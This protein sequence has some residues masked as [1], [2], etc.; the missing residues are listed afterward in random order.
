MPVT[1]EDMRTVERVA[2]RFVRFVQSSER[3]E[4]VSDGMLALA[5]AVTDWE[6]DRSLRQSCRNN[7]SGFIGG[8]V[9]RGMIDGIRQRNGRAKSGYGKQRFR[10]SALSLDYPV[11]RDSSAKNRT[12]SLLDLTGE[13]DADLER[14]GESEYVAQMLSRLPA[15]EREVVERNVLGGETE[16]SIAKDLGV[17]ESRISQLISRALSRLRDEPVPTPREQA[18]TPRSANT[19]SQ[20]EVAVLQEVANDKSNKEIA[21]ALLIGEETVKSHLRHIHSK[22]GVSHRAGAVARGFRL[23]VLR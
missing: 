1:R 13:P 15:R 11:H 16:A 14:V 5:Q 7:R 10:E 9:K 12:T 8:R 23:R 20:R 18:P 6:G 2:S 19:L 3:N 22:L 21:R 17:S 4:A